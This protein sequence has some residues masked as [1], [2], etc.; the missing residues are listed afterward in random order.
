MTERINGFDALRQRVLERRDEVAH[1]I[2]VKLRP[3]TSH[4]STI[5]AEI[6]SYL[7]SLPDEQRFG[8]VADALKPTTPSLSTRPSQARRRSS[9][10]CTRP[11]RRSCGR[12]AWPSWP[13]TWG[14]KPA[15]T[16][17]PTA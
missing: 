4:E 3:A 10:G 14:W 16:L 1:E 8:A 13:P 6:R 5:A 9:A 11:G 12:S 17:R 7:R 15:W 2:D